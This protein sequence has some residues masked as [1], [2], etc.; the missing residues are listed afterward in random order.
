MNGLLGLQ[1]Q[2]ASCR[3]FAFQPGLPVVRRSVNSETGDSANRGNG[4]QQEEDSSPSGMGGVGSQRSGN[5]SAGKG[6]DG[7]PT[8]YGRGGQLSQAEIDFAIT[9]ALFAREVMERQ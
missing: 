8:L 3:A 6:N 2:Q 7:A 5:S 1:Y 4:V 9:R